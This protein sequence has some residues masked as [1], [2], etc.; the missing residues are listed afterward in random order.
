MSIFG[1]QSLQQ[2]HDLAQK[3]FEDIL[4]IYC[5]SVNEMPFADKLFDG[6][7]CYGLIHLL[8]KNEN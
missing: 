3:H 5:G 1:R 8:D 7:Y 4:E 2:Q 6:I